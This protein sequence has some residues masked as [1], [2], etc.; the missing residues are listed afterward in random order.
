[1]PFCRWPL[2]S[3]QCTNR[4]NFFGPTLYKLRYINL[5]A[6]LFLLLLLHWRLHL[7]LSLAMVYS[8]LYLRNIT[9]HMRSNSVSLPPRLLQFFTSNIRQGIVPVAIPFRCGGK[10]NDSF[11]ADYLTSL[12]VKGFW[13][14]VTL[15]QRHDEYHK[16]SN[17][18]EHSVVLGRVEN[19][20]K[21]GKKYFKFCIK[22]AEIT[23]KMA[24]NHK[25]ENHYIV[26]RSCL[27]YTS[28]SPRD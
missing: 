17:F 5:L 12:S 11:V 18:F 24:S 20:G 23:A 8:S 10:F 16:A 25:P 28:P 9:C 19:C 1:M 4:S 15:W 22:I 13:K 26:Y 14:L 2:Q 21:N 6:Y 27:L 3:Y 7:G